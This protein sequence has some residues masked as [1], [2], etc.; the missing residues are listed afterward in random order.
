VRLPIPART[1]I[2]FGLL[3]L[4]ARAQAAPVDDAIRAEMAKRHIPGL[5]VA[6]LKT[7]KPATIKSYGLANL[8]TGAAVT[9]QTV[10]KIASLSKA[11]IADAVLLLAQENKL[12]LD[13]RVSK[14]LTDAPRTWRDITVRQLLNHTSG[15]VRDPADYHPY[16]PQPVMDVVRS[17]YGLPLATP[18]GEKFLYSNIGYYVL[19][20]IASR[21]SGQSWDSYIAAHFFVP[22]GMTATRTTTP[23]IM[24]GRA[25]GYYWRNNR[26][27]NAENW[28]AVRPSGAFL[29]SAQDMARWD[30]FQLSPAFPLN[31]ASRTQAV[32]MGHLNGGAPSNYGF[33]WTIDSFLGQTRIHHDGQYPGFRSDYEK[34]RD[35]ADQFRKWQCGRVG[36]ENRRFLRSITGDAAL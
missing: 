33:G 17:A 28:V 20:E 21:V 16:D 14:Y 22:A 27:L 24:P 12:A 8:E 11:F 35:P 9:P 25:S 2:L 34:D 7:G 30:A 26:Y 31:R 13:D 18:P 23:E 10:F 29:S 6:V 19:A 5:S 3:L 32:A 1:A 15:I 4:S 36:A